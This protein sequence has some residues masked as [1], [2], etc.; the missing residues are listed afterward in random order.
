MKNRRGTQ[1]DQ[2]VEVEVE[3]PKRVSKK[4][5]ELYEKIRNGQTE[6]PFE[7]FKKAFK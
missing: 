5:R 7:R 4:E 1:G 2:Y 3:I 6:S